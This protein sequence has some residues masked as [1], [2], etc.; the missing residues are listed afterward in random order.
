[1]PSPKAKHVTLACT[2]VAPL[3]WAP[4]CHGIADV[5][6]TVSSSSV[7][8]AGPVRR[9]FPPGDRPGVF[10]LR[11]LCARREHGTTEGMLWPCGAVVV[12]IK[13][14]GSGYTST[15]V[16]STDHGPAPL[17][18]ATR[19]GRRAK[20]PQRPLFRRNKTLAFSPAFSGVGYRP[21][22]KTG[23]DP[24]FWRQA[25]GL[26]PLDFAYDLAFLPGFSFL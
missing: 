5:D 1:M 10:F 7:A 22:P 11:C 19:D 2:T 24:R 12:D 14:R 6:R 3:T 4:C 23:P 25:Q 20:R 15:I 16:L 26:K 9:S 21:P 18:P 17:G 13:P 8:P